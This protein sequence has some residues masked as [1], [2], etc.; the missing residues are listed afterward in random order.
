VIGASCPGGRDH[1]GCRDGRGMAGGRA[2]GS[3]SRRR[4]RGGGS[5]RNRCSGVRRLWFGCRRWGLLRRRGSRRRSRCRGRRRRSWR[6]GRWT[7]WWTDRGGSG[8]WRGRWSACRSIGMGQR[9]MRRYAHDDHPHAHRQ[10][11]SDCD[12]PLHAGLLAHVFTN[13]QGKP[14]LSPYIIQA[15]FRSVNDCFM[16]CS[17]RLHARLMILSRTVLPISGRRKAH[18]MDLRYTARQP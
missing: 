18:D 9:L 3:G 13:Y 11:Y 8:R 16:F 5:G 17:C 15:V 6:E 10:C 12:A 7:R 1:C 14:D 2:R 4:R